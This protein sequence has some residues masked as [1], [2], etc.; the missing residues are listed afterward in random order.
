MSDARLRDQFSARGPEVLD[1]FSEQKFL[2]QWDAVLEDNSES[3]VDA[4]LA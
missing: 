3:E 2:A 1:R 4:I